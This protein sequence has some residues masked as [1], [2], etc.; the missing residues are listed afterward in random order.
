MKSNKQRRQEL[1]EKRRRRTQKKLGVRPTGVGRGLLK[2]LPKG[3][4]AADLSQQVP[5]NSYSLPPTFY[6]DQPFTCKDCG[7]REVWTAE[8]Q[9]WWYEVA[10]GP[11]FS[12]AVRCRSCRKIERDRKAEARRVHLE[13]IAQ[14]LARQQAES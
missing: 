14:K 11:V 2:R 6:I 5:N 12:I 4:I 7:A 10:K 3:A 9:K 13:G 8:R 1:R